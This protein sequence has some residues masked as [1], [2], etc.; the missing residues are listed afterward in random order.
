VRYYVIIYLTSIAG[1]LIGGGLAAFAAVER[2]RRR[3]RR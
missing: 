1:I 2:I 3:R